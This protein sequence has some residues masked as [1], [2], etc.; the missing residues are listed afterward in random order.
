MSLFRSEEHVREWCAKNNLG[1]DGLLS[2]TQVWGMAQAWYSEDRRSAE[3]KRKSKD[4]AQTL[5]TSLGLTSAFW[6]L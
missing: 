6:Q 5:F 2:L 3:W 4:E 1:M